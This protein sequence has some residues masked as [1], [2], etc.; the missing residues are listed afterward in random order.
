MIAICRTK[1]QVVDVP[2]HSPTPLAETGWIVSSPD[3][4]ASYV[5]AWKNV[6]SL[7]EGLDDARLIAEFGSLSGLTSDRIPV[8]QSAAVEAYADVRV[9]GEVDTDKVRVYEP[10]LE[11]MRSRFAELKS[12][13]EAA[14][15]VE[16][17]T[18]R[19]R[20]YRKIG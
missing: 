7:S 11:H 13:M 4:P 5:E 3:A 18:L 16:I 1:A 9:R 6:L 12:P 20:R 10:T 17:V 8:D 15:S 2:N 14:G 19:V